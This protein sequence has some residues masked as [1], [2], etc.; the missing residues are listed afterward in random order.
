MPHWR[1][2]YFP[3]LGF[4]S[5]DFGL[6]VLIPDCGQIR[7]ENI[8]FHFRIL[9]LELAGKN[10]PETFRKNLVKML[11]NFLYLKVILIYSEPD[12]SHGMTKL[13]EQ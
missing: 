11:Q 13:S 3:F 4:N 2:C 12:C 5:L 8:V 10:A 1:Q 7:S 9:V 6:Y